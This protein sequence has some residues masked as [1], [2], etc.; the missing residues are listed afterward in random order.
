VSVRAPSIA[1]AIW[2]QKDMRSPSG[3]EARRRGGTQVGKAPPSPEMTISGLTRGRLVGEDQIANQDLPRLCRTCGPPLRR[4]VSFL[5]S[6]HRATWPWSQVVDH[7]QDAAEQVTRHRHLGH[8]E[9]RVAGVSDHLRADLHHLLAKRGQRPAL[10]LI[11]QNQR[12]EE[13]GQVVGQRMKLEPDRV[14]LHRPA[15]QACPP[16]AFLPSLI[17]CSAVP[18]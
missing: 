15:R 14:G 18:R 13:V 5:G 10:D 16:D 11:G 4:A 9:H 6:Q 1:A 12:A 2:S 3:G 7:R 17:H 8:L